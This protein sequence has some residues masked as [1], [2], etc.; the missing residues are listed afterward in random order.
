MFILI[1]SEWNHTASLKWFIYSKK[2][3]NS[4]FQS[5]PLEQT[6]EENDSTVPEQYYSDDQYASQNSRA[7]PRTLDSYFNDSEN[8][9]TV[10]SSKRQY[11][12]EEKSSDWLY[13]NPL[14]SVKKQKSEESKEP[15]TSL[16]PADIPKTNVTETTDNRMK[17]IAD[18][19]S[20]I[21]ETTETFQQKNPQVEANVD[22]TTGPGDPLISDELKEWL[23]K[24]SW[25]LSCFNIYY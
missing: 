10:K 11:D 21:E 18:I 22:T 7:R 14:P 9:A 24:F 16:K 6:N 23:K 8:N 3:F 17:N 12:N 20:S 25:I 2:K 5:A 1:E 13:A 4:L 15:S 19:I